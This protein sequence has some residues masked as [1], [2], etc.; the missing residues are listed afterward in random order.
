MSGKPKRRRYVSLLPE[1]IPVYLAWENMRRRCLNPNT[2]NFFNYGVRGISLH[3][4]WAVSFVSFWEY[5]GPRPSHGHSIDRYPD[6]NG[7][8]E[9]GNVRWATRTEQNSNKR[10]YRSHSLSTRKNK[11]SRYKGVSVYRNGEWR[12]EFGRKHL[13]V[14]KEE[15]DAATAYNFA[16]FERY[17]GSG[18]Y[19]TPRGVLPCRI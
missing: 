11:A 15:S 8:Y 10:P 12:A 17:G 16:A 4:Q 2:T 5:V 14:F 18:I 1:Q 7:N 3:P 9:P 13:G 19:N 6:N